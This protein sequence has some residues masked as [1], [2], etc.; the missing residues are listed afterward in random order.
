MTRIY[1]IT[2]C[3]GFEERNIPSEPFFS[4][5]S[6]AAVPFLGE[7]GLGVVVVRTV[8]RSPLGDCGFPDAFELRAAVPDFFGAGFFAGAVGGVAGSFAGVASC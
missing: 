7:D 3:A 5:F 1:G 6:A 2:R 4:L 8:S